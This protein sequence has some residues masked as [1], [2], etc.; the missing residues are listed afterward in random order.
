M[1]KVLHITSSYMPPKI[2]GDYD[3][4]KVKYPSA[5]HYTGARVGGIP[6][7]ID[8][9][10]THLD[11][12]EHHV[13]L[14]QDGQPYNFSGHIAQDKR[15][16]ITI[17]YFPCAGKADDL[18]KVK[19]TFPK[20]LENAYPEFQFD[21]IITHVANP[22]FDLS[23]INK[24]VRWINCTHGSN[25]C[26]KLPEVYHDL[27]DANHIMSEWQ[28]KRATNLKNVKLIPMGVDTNLFR[29]DLRLGDFSCVWHGRI[30]PE[31]EIIPFANE[32]SVR[33]PLDKLYIIGG[34]DHPPHDKGWKIKDNVIKLGRLYDE[35]LAAELRKHEFYMLP[36]PHET[37]CVA[38]L[39]AMASGCEL[40]CRDIEGLGWVPDNCSWKE[41]GR[42]QMLDRYNRRGFD[43]YGRGEKGQYARKFVE[44]NYSWGILKERY[45]EMLG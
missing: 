16:N 44:E 39:E 20:L 28:R 9:M 7:V 17:H 15:D 21:I 1:K 27:I 25:G 41:R 26:A 14:Q 34:P 33:N 35:K 43:S 8:S 11:G 3:C 29:P 2:E 5:E 45:E 37:F 13:L 32:F 42:K 23:K 19:Y 10:A 18:P 6:A 24:A 31:K 40:I 12:Y 38:A 22:A 4:I 36:S 30:A